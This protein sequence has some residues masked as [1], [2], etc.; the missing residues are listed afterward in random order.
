MRDKIDSCLKQKQFTQYTASRIRNLEI[1]NDDTKS[2]FN[3]S[4]NIQIILNYASNKR[5]VYEE[6][7]MFD[8]TS[9]VGSLGGSLGLFVGFSFFG[10]A[11]P[12]IEAIFDKVA[13][14]FERLR[15][16]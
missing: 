1:G 3:D 14:C 9:L 2:L 11:M 15:N 10:Y 8:E 6:V 7:F 4:M 16:K 5:N 13:D 12:I